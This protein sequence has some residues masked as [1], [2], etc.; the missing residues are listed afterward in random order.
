MQIKRYSLFSLFFIL[1]IVFYTYYFVSNGSIS[2]DFFGI[3][4]PKLPVPFLIAVPLIIYFFLS[5]SHMLFYNVKNYFSLRTLK[6]DHDNLEEFLYNKL[7]GIEKKLTFRSDSYKDL[8]KLVDNINMS[9]VYKDLDISNEKLKTVFNLAKRIN[10]GEYIEDM[11]LIKK[12]NLLAANSINRFNLNKEDYEWV[13]ANSNL[14]PKDLCFDAYES[15]AKKGTLKLVLENKEF[16]NKKSLEYILLRLGKDEDFS[17]SLDELL[18]LIEN[19]SL[20]KDDFINISK[21]LKSSSSPDF[22]LK[23]LS[24]LKDKY[25]EAKEAYLYTLFDLEILEDAREIISSSEDNEYKKL[26]VYSMLKEEN[27]NVELE[28]FI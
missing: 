15:L 8:A 10:S 2:L 6:K 3:N 16:L 18:K 1:T 24:A 25:D 11:P 21:F 23:V 7:L 26:R 14:Y 17:L 20:N 19:I 5:L 13:F 28:I 22:R 27:K 9:F 4:L 12:S